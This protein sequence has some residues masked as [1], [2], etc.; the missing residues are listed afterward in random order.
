MILDPTIANWVLVPA[1]KKEAMWQLLSGTFVLPRGTTEKV[2]YYATKM[3]GE[4]F[5]RWKSHLITEYV[6]KG[7]TP[8]SEF[9]DITPAQWEEFVRQKTTE[10][11]LALSQKNRELAQS[12]IHKVRLGPGGCQRKVDQWRHQREAAIAAGQPD[13]YERLD[14]RGWQ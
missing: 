2:K 14:E 7:Q 9:G 8:F 4:A 1:G 3:L 12:N 10:E 6:Q 13:P 5:R 11:A